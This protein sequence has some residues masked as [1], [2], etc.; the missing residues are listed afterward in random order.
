MK[1]FFMNIL[2]IFLPWLALLISDNPGA[3]ILALMMQAT[4]IGWIPASMWAWRVVQEEAF[5]QRIEAKRKK[6]LKKTKK[7]EL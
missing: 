6:A 2:A 7:K 4:I 1:L 5:A 3:A